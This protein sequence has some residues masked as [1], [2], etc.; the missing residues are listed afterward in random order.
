MLLLE[1]IDDDIL[2]INVSKNEVLSS[3][4]QRNGQ[5]QEKW[6][7]VYEYNAD[8]YPTK[9][10]EKKVGRDNSTYEDIMNLEYNK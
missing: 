1:L 8:G 4:T 7:F 5:F 9:I 3:E 10:T 6:D 2:G